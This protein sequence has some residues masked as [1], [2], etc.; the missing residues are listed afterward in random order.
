MVGCMSAIPE[1]YLDLLDKKSFAHLS[2]LMKDG[3]PQVSPVWID[4]DGE[5]IVVNS[6]QG[7]VK[8][9]NMRRDARVA[10]SLIDPEN[11]YR[12]LMIR[13]RVV[14]ITVEGADEHIDRMA[15]KYI[16]KDKY[17]FRAPGEVRVLYR[18]QPERVSTMG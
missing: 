10:L 5:H 4:R 18:I 16:D 1:T 17:P 3:S 11:P 6:A 7:R 2:T 13:G 8:D 12:A 14:D 15:K 9:R